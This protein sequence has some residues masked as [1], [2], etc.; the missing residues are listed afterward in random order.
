VID[1]AGELIDSELDPYQGVY[2]ETV[3]QSAGV[4][5]VRVLPYGVDAGLPY[6]LAIWVD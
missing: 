3:A 4:Y 6:D 5:T 2:L 1:P